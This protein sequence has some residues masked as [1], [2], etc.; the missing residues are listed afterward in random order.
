MRR[1]LMASAALFGM[2]MALGCSSEQPT[3]QGRM[4]VQGRVS[5]DLSIDNARAVAVGDNGRTYWAHLDAQRDFRLRL[6]VGQSYRIVIANQLPGGG[7][8]IVGRMVLPAGEGRTVWLGANDS[9]VVN[10]GTLRP[11]SAT[12]ES[13]GVRPQCA[14]CGEGDGD[15]DDGAYHDDDNECYDGDYVDEGWEKD[16]E[17]TKDGKGGGEADK[18]TGDKTEEKPEGKPEEKPA[19]DKTS[20]KDKGAEAE[21][22]PGKDVEQCKICKGESKE[23]DLEPSK[24]PSKKFEDK[25]PEKHKD[26]K[27]ASEKEKTCPKKAPSK[28]S[29]DEETNKTPEKPAGDGSAPEEKK[30]SGDESSE[31]KPTGG[32]QAEGDACKLNTDCVE[33]LECIANMCVIPK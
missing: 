32:T 23:T 9:D 13:G 29:G 19:E 14:D 5:Q 3:A 1:F 17:P 21:K 18:G 28:P 27:G 20:E 11:A 15:S 2:A 12:A 4:T 7:Q 30:P 22:V 33:K 8:V 26:S 6:P 10:L 31:D 16:G 24:K 25:Y